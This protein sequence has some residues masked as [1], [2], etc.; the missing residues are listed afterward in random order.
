MSKP[1]KTATIVT[2]R[3]I[4]LTFIAIMVIALFSA[5]IVDHNVSNAFPGSSFFNKFKAHLGLDLQGGTH[6][7]YQ[8]DMKAIPAKDRDNAL[9]GVRD[10]IERRINAFGVSEPLV[11]TQSGDRLVVEM[12]GIKDVNQAIRQIAKLHFWNSKKRAHKCKTPLEPLLI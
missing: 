6:L 1:F 7:V 8:A 11:Q 3:R 12:A 2:R 5:A 4:W 10:V 9:G